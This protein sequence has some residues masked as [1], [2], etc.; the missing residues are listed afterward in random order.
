MQEL[1]QLVFTNDLKDCL[2]PVTMKWKPP[3]H[4]NKILGKLLKPKSV[5]GTN[6]KEENDVSNAT[7]LTNKFIA[8]IKTTENN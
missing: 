8:L 3:Q 2:H 5:K 1:I 7:P 6:N 4:Q